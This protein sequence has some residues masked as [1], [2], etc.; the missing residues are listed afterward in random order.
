[1]P[2]KS[3]V[4]VA[5]YFH[6]FM[7][8]TKKNE[9]SAVTYTA[10]EIAEKHIRAAFNGKKLS[11]LTRM[12]CQEFIS[13]FAETHAHN[14]TSDMYTKLKCA[15]DYATYDGLI[16]RNPCFRL[17]VGGA[18]TEREKILHVAESLSIEEARKL[19][20]QLEPLELDTP[21][22]LKRVNSMPQPYD[23]MIL[24][25]LRTGMRIA[26]VYGLTWDRVDLS[27]K[28]FIRVDRSRNYKEEGG[29]VFKPTKTKS[30][31]R[32]IPI[33]DDLAD[34]LLEFKRLYPPESDE[35][36]LFPA[37]GL[38]RIA[39]P[40]A[41]NNRMTIL[42]EKAKVPRIHF[43]QLRH[44]HGSILLAQGVPLIAISRRLGHANVSITQ[45]VYLHE[46]EEAKKRNDDQI[47]TAMEVIS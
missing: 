23:L 35:D 25:A 29:D 17:T 47:I 9:V 18:K 12:E 36:L 7:V 40:A 45:Q 15:L 43:H 46:I 5:G 19:T 44:T 42:C 10:Y 6:S 28:P 11:S 30:S 33:D 41:I 22:G 13:R 16:D 21:T 37:T 38:A 3:Q 34:T 31:I 27:R 26:E 1:M 4:T 8:N 2:R 39:V 32:D 20:D 24:I 14:T